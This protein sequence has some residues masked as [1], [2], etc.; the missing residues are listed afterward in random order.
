MRLEKRFDDMAD[1]VI[2]EITFHREELRSIFIGPELFERMKRQEESMK[3]EDVVYV[4]Y[5][6][7]KIVNSERARRGHQIEVVPRNILSLANDAPKGRRIVL[8]T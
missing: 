2:Y 3:L 8:D 7:A 1:D 4:L 5:E 6:L